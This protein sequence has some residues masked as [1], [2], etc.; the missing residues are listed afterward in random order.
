ML[1]K[2][3]EDNGD[4]VIIQEIDAKFSSWNIKPTFLAHKRDLVIVKP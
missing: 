4:R 1:K 2:V 3:V